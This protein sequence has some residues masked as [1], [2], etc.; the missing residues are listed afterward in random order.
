M[1]R[2]HIGPPVDGFLNVLAFTGRHWSWQPARVATIMISMFACTLADVLT[3][4]YTGRLVDAVAD[5]AATQDVAWQA[6][7]AAFSML[8]GLAL[9]AIVMRHVAFTC[10]IELT[11][12]MLCDISSEAF[13]RVQRFSTDWHANSF[14]GSTVRQITRGMGALDLLNST[15]LI[16]LFPSLIMLIGSAVLLGWHWP[17]M[18]LI[19]ACGSLAYVG[20]T[21]TLTLE[22]IAPPASLA[23][24]WDSRLGG[25]LAD[26][27]SCNPVV[28]GF[29]AEQRENERLAKTRCGLALESSQSRKNRSSRGT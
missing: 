7:L 19:T 14:A 29:A 13:D 23:N 18:G 15:I 6:A 28:K 1:S 27:I 10:I 26:A 25:A 3:P 24:S 11:L 17:M 22:Y 4:L 8:I 5:G 2:F 9:G 21:I 20:L 12:K 16:A